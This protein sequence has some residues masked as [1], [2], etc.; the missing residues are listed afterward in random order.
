M[1]KCLPCSLS[2]KI[3]ANF[4]F[5]VSTTKA[6]TTNPSRCLFSGRVHSAVTSSLDTATAAQAPERNP[7]KAGHE[8][9]L[10]GIIQSKCS[11]KREPDL[12]IA[13]AHLQLSMAHGQGLVLVV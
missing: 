6:I 3:D 9:D 7:V 13:L 11:G 4:L 1:C 5:S 10:P 2:F 8:F 12:D